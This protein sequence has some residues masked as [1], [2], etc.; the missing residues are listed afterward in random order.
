MWLQFVILLLVKNAFSLEVTRFTNVECEMLDP[1]YA[2]FEQCE[3]KILGRGI[4]G[5]N[6]YA[7]LNKGPFNNAKINIS[8]WRKFN[9]YRPFIFNK[10][11][12]FCNYMKNPN[13]KLSFEKIFLDSIFT[14]SNLN[15][16]CPFDVSQN[17]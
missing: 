1:S 5:L 14:N 10:T 6:I 17:V 11:F 12:D 7:K 15:H 4:I 9:G 3:L 8:L 16:S 13:G 2:T